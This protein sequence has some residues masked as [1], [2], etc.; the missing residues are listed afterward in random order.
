MNIGIDFH[1]TISF[2]P[3]YFRNL[4]FIWRS[5]KVGEVY[6]V[7]G[8]P[9]SLKEK[10]IEQLKDLE[11]HKNVHYTDILMGFEY[12]KEKMSIAHFKKMRKHK[13]DLVKKNKI[14][15]YYDDNPYYA[16]WMKEHN[17]ITFMPCV[18]KK[19]IGDFAKKDAFFSCHLQEKIF[20]F[21]ELLTD[22]DVLK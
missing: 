3:E 14:D 6:V 21:L 9:E 15:I 10:T 12:Q 2:A 13:L 19:Y 18:N 4:M 11:I 20:N 16:Q 5:N 17:I 1:D 8:T 22:K 7:T